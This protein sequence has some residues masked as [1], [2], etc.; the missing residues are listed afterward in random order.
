MAGIVIQDV[1]VKLWLKRQELSGIAVLE[2]YLQ[3]MAKNRLLDLL[4]LRDIRDRHKKYYAILQPAS[5]NNTREQLQ[6][7]EYLAIAREGMDKMPLRRRVIFS[8]S[9]LEG[10]SI[11]EI[12]A[13]MQ[14]SRDVVKKQLQKARTFLKEYISKHGDLPGAICLAIIGGYLGIS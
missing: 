12:A 10:F 3:R 14:V 6:L 2:Y 13:Q 8:M 11:D 4:K 5:A 1:F 7:K 9:V